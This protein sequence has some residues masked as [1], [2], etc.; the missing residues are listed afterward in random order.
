M[1]TTREKIVA[2]SDR[3]EHPAEIAAA[4]GVGLS[5]VYTILQKHRP[6]RERKPRVRNGQVRK[7]ITFDLR[8]TKLSPAQIAA[9][10]GCTRQYVYK[11]MGEGG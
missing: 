2:R 9:K 11:L 7:D 6:D 8:V 4:V 10:R 1:T 3:G 5:R